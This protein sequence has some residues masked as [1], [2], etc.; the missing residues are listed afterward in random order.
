M[1][2]AFKI[3]DLGVLK[4][5]LGIELARSSKW[6]HRRY[7]LDILDETSFLDCK[8]APSPIVPSRKLAHGDSAP[9]AY[10]NSYRRLVERLLY[11]YLTTTKPDITFAVQQLSQFIGSPT[12]IHL[13][14]VHKVLRFFKSALGKGLFFPTTS[15]IHVQAFADAN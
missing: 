5:F 7:I 3:K 8:P 10:V 12:Q 13:V 4:Y 15:T 6:L 11:L 9:L 2:E 14:A 1:D